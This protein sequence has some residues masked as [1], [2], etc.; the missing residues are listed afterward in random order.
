MSNPKP[1]MLYIGT[2]GLPCFSADFEK[3]LDKF[4]HDRLMLSSEMIMLMQHISNRCKSCRGSRGQQYKQVMKH[5][6]IEKLSEV[7][8]TIQF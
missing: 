8:T 2:N 4:Q 6:D 7:D 5:C 1:E 3:A